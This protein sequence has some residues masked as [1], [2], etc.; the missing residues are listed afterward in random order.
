MLSYF[1]GG[2]VTKMRCN[3]FIMMEPYWRAL[4]SSWHHLQT[5]ENLIVLKMKVQW[6]YSTWLHQL[7]CQIRKAKP[8]MCE[9]F[10]KETNSFLWRFFKGGKTF[11]KSKKTSINFKGWMTIMWKEEKESQLS[12]EKTLTT[13]HYTGWLIGIL[14]MV[15]YN[16]Y[17]TG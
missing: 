16:P 15:Y 7:F 5:W 3:T 2:S 8:K 14:I 11:E 4:I 13:F 9:K 1:F 12:H 17:I 10:K 6:F